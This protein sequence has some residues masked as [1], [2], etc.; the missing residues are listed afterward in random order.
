MRN[1]VVIEK[2]IGYTQRIMKYSSGLSYE[3]FVSDS[4]IIDACVFNLSQI[5]ELTSNIDES[6]E[7]E[8][9]SVMW[10]QMETELYMIMKA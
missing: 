4:M 8:H 9:P 2:M 3:E 7:N 5:G 6:F 10:R 1:E